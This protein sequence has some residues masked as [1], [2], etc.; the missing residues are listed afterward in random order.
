MAGEFLGRFGRDGA[1][2]VDHDVD[3]AEVLD[4]GVDGSLN[5]LFLA[6]VTDHRDAL[7]ARGLDVGDGGV[8]GARQLGMRLGG[9]GQ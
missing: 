2:V 9:F 3:A 1:G 4:R 8:H 6:H 7:A 5:V